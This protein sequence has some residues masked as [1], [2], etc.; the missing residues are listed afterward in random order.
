VKTLRA[1]SVVCLAF[2]A[3]GCAVDDHQPM[4]FEDASSFSTIDFATVN[5]KVFKKS[6]TGCHSKTHVP[7]ATFSEIKAALHGIE[8]DVFVKRSMPKDG[9]LT[10]MQRAL[11]RK[12]IDAGGPKVENEKPTE[13]G[14]RPPGTWK[15]MREQF[16]NVSCAGCHYKDNPEG[17]TNL[18]D[19]AVFKGSIDS[20]LFLSF[21]S[22]DAPMPPIDKPQLTD[23][24]KRLLTEWIIANQPEE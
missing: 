17:L 19:V 21:L 4:V 1:L 3:A 6:C 14:E 24:Q 23:E 8:D 9:S 12:W 11:L 7:L 10:A 15:A 13:P 18:T 22:K 16:V 20:I 2:F 5:E